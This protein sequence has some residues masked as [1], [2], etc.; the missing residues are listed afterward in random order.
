MNKVS[1]AIAIAAIGVA[2]LSACKKEA[3][4][5][6]LDVRATMQDRV[7]P[8]MTAIWDVGNNALDDN[9]GLDPAL[10][11]DAKWAIIAGNADKLAAAGT[12]ISNA[13]SFVSAAADNSTVGEGEIT[14]A[15]VQQHVDGNPDGLKQ[16]GAAL[17]DS[18][19]R[20]ATAARA[21]DAKTAG[22]L[23]SGMDQVCES[24]HLE[25][26]YPEQKELVA[27]AEGE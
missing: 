27:E 9:G 7:N 1:S 15:A 16:M 20:L 10:L 21:R 22:D 25:F 3:A 6:P 11:D 18:A 8:A 4:A 12:A 26:W 24:C 14:M 19:T 23:I 17:A 13:G 2:A 5:A